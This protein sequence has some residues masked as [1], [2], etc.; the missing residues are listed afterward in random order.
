MMKRIVFLFLLFVSLFAQ[1]SNTTKENNVEPY[2]MYGEANAKSVAGAA[3]VLVWTACWNKD[4]FSNYFDEVGG[5][6]KELP[7]EFQYMDIIGK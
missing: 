6:R 7:K 2:V 5:K 3:V 1:D 4:K